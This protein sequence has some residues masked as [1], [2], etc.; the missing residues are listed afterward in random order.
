[1]MMRTQEK[2]VELFPASL[3]S[4]SKRWMVVSAILGTYL[5]FDHFVFASCSDASQYSILL[6]V[7]NIYTDMYI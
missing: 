5:F 1:M 4:P 3:L 6:I 2:V 7:S